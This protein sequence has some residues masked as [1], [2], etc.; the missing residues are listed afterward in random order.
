[1]AIMAAGDVHKYGEVKNH[2]YDKHNDVARQIFIFTS[3]TDGWRDMFKNENFA[4]A[5]D[6]SEG[7]VFQ[8][9][10]DFVSLISVHAVV[11]P[12]AS[13]NLRHKSDVMFAAAGESYGTHN[14][15]GAYG[16]EAVVQWRM[17]ELVDISS[18]F[19]NL[20]ALDYVGLRFY[21][22]GTHANDTVNDSVAF[23]GFV[24]KY[25]AHQ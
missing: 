6:K 5:S 23:L 14:N 13:G 7:V 17:E 16:D 15:A 10:A 22:E 1:M 12:A 24:F 25:T 20:A 3:E 21:R 8:V 18:Q 2:S 4:D 19:T 9:P 11:I